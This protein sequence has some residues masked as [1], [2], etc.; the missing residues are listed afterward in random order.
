[1]LLLSDI[2]TDPELGG[3]A[4]TILRDHMILQSGE[5]LLESRKSFAT[6]GVVQ[7][8]RDQDLSL[9]PEE[10][11]SEKLYTFYSPIPFSL[12]SRPDA[13][14]FTAPDRIVWQDRCFLV[15]AMKD[16]TPFG[17]SRAIAVE[18]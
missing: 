10:Y 3:S 6:F 12:G 15:I 5:S 16:W 18:K 17:F 4:F 1:M 13:A 9:V 14:H 7:P 8:A 11:R 2:A